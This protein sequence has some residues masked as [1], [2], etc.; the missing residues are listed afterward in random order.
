M[1]EI[2]VI[3]I[4]KR[5]GD[6]VALDGVDLF[7]PDGVIMAVVGPSGSGKTTLLRVIAGLET[8]DSGKVLFDD[9][10]VTRLPSSVRNVGMVFQD[11]A[12][13]PHMTVLENVMFGL[14]ARGFGRGESI[15][16][17]KEF[18]ELL[19][20]DGLERRY[21]HQLSGG[22]QQ[23]VAIARALAPD[24]DVILLDEPFGSLDAKL[25]EELL[26]EI[27]KLWMKRKFTALHVTHDQAEAMSLAER[28]A[29]MR[30]GRIV[31][32][33]SVDDVVMDPRDEFVAR[34]LGANVIEMKEVKEGLYSLDNFSIDYKPGLQAIKVGFYPEDVE[35]GPG[36]KV[37]I[38]ASSRHRSGYRVIVEDEGRSQFELWLPSIPGN[39][40]EMRP[41]RWFV[42]KG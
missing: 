12:L 28:L 3:G 31:R 6:T 23:R 16:I 18:L 35:L 39:T 22:Q 20:L 33:G 15:R 26:W 21:P 19:R 4:R 14:E 9:R 41:R 34:F 32:E 10:D 17:A 2:R 37:R 25:K 30:N 7:I 8:P 27:K 1:A 29:V 24:P 5:F 36:I 11:L 13:F 40:F 42:L 38:V